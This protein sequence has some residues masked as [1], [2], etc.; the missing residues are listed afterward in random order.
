MPFIKSLNVVINKVPK[1]NT[2]EN[3]IH[4]FSCILKKKTIREA[5]IKHYDD[6]LFT[7][8]KGGMKKT[9]QTIS[10]KSNMKRKTL[11]KIIVDSKV[12]IEKEEI[13][14]KF[15]E[16]FA[17]IGPKLAT[18]IKPASNKTFDYFLKKRVLVLLTSNWSTRMTY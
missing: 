18:Q 3:N 16:F 10:Y 9:W 6:K 14:N 8:Y 13:C 2:L 15:N 5:K 4:V 7:Q 11:D 1:Y 17:N 12:N